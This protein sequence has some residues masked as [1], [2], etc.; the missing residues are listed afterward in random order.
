MMDTASWLYQHVI[1]RQTSLDDDLKKAYTSL[2]QFRDDLVLVKQRICDPTNLPAMATLLTLA[3]D[4]EWIKKRFSVKFGHAAIEKALKE[5]DGEV[6]NAG[7][8]GYYTGNC[9]LLL[10]VER[11]VQAREVDE[12]LMPT[13]IS[14]LKLNGFR[15]EPV[16][17]KVQVLKESL[18]LG[19]ITAS[20]VKRAYTIAKNRPDWRGHSFVK[21]RAREVVED[22]GL[23]RIIEVWKTVVTE[24]K[25]VVNIDTLEEAFKMILEPHVE[26]C[27]DE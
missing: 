11:M 16:N 25:Q 26:E 7:D 5:S 15:E 19:G 14:Q 8:V 6:I 27:M 21:K 2:Q 18:Q 22:A 24:G 10:A 3:R 4:S 20:N 23:D 1:N 17:A 9:E 12:L 13:G